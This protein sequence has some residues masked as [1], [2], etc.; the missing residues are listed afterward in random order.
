MTP[1]QILAY[2]LVAA[3]GTAVVLTREPKRQALI[4]S[5]YG[6]ALTVLFLVLQSPDVALSELT[7]GAAALPLMLLVALANIHEQRPTESPDKSEPES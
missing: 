7:V 6:M 2:A 3:G 5:L 1:L 4:L